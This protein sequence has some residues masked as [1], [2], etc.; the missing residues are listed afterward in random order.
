MT[1][2]Q[3]IKEILKNKNITQTQLAEGIG[4]TRQNLNN[5]MNRDNFSAKE[6]SKIADVLGVAFVIKDGGKIEYN[7]QYTDEQTGKPE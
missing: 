1:V 6:L 2:A 3:A 4:T 5:K 7:I